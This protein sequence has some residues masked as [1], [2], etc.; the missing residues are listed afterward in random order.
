MPGD[1]GAGVMLPSGDGENIMLEGSGELIVL[2]RL[3]DS[4]LPG[5]AMLGDLAVSLIGVAI[6]IS[7]TSYPML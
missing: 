6:A 2:N 5:V 7:G 4:I 3:G 1:V